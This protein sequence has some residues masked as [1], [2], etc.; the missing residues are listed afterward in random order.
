MKENYVTFR[1]FTK[2]VNN[3][4]KGATSEVKQTRQSIMYL[5]NTLNKLYR[6]NE[7]ASN[8]N[9]REF[10]RDLRLYCI[11]HGIDVPTNSPFNAYVFTKVGGVVCYKY[12]NR[13]S[14]KSGAFAIVEDIVVWKKVTLTERGILSAYKHLINSWLKRA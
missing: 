6:K 4:Y 9:L 13:T 2:V 10:A 11:E 14:T 7:Y 8:T 1:E 5:V 3:D 12:T